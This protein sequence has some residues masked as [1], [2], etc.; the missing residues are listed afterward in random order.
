M[1]VEKILEDLVMINTVQDKENEKIISY[2]ENFLKEYDFKVIKKDKY[3]IMESNFGKEEI[4]VGFIGHTDTVPALDT[5]GYDPFKL[6]RVDNKLYGL[7][8]CD[9][10]GGIAAI[11]DAVSKVNLK[12]LKNGLKLFFT[13]DEEV[14]FGG[15]K[16]AYAIQAGRELR[17]IV[18]CEKVSDELAA[19]LSF[20]ISHKIQTEMT[21]PGQVKITVIRETRA[22]SFAK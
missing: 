11:L 5:W 19:N 8:T 3:L 9:M 14:G 21:Y 17:V 13:F 18:D 4:G 7:G 1:S 15:I 20:Q 12:T 6:T 10:K 22:V 2:L 16:N